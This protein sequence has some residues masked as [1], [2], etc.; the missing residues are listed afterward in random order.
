MDLVPANPEDST[1]TNYASDTVE[2][3][4]SAGVGRRTVLKAAAW[5]APVIAL[6]VAVPAA[7]ASGTEPEEPEEPQR[8][9]TAIWYVGNGYGQTFADRVELVE[10]GQGKTIIYQTFLVMTFDTLAAA[11]NSPYVNIDFLN[12]GGRHYGWK[13]DNYPNPNLNDP[14]FT[15]EMPTV[16]EILDGG[17]SFKVK[18]PTGLVGPR[19]VQPAGR[20]VHYNQRDQNHCFPIE[21]GL[22]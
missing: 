1:S 11:G 16:P 15:R 3:P 21:W 2:A 12:G 18:Y 14:G 10:P 22:G 19:W 13:F 7:S 20:N 8:N 5:S 6:A 9:C 4:A 17:L